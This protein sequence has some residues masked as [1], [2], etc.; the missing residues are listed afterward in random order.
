M[1]WVD[2]VIVV[3]IAAAV[4]GGISQGFFR[5]VCTFFGLLLGL[6][7]ASWNYHLVGDLFT[8]IIKL[9]ALTDTI[10]FLAIAL[11]VMGLASVAGTTLSK[12]VHGMGLGCLDRLAGAVFGFFQGALLVMG[13]VLAG[14]AFYPGARWLSEAKLPKVFFGAC[15]L[16]A[17]LSPDDMAGR[18]RHGLAAIEE[19][20]PQWMHPGKGGV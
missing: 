3:L 13:L 7:L 19:E 1:G 6:A 2:L 17:R 10:G 20:T 11:I 4:L 14:L 9:E 15:Y 5:S 8:P 12:A 16:T 18:I